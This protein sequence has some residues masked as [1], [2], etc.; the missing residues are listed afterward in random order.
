MEE[1]ANQVAESSVEHEIEERLRKLRK[2]QPF[3]GVHACPGS[4]LDVPDEQAA[5]LVILRPADAYES[6]NK[7]NKEIVTAILDTHGE[8]R[9]VYR[10]MLAF[11]APQQDKMISLNQAA[12][13]FLAWKSIKDDREQL[14]LDKSQERE[15]ESNLKNSDCAIEEQI[16]EAYKW[17]LVPFV[18]KQVDMHAIFWDA[19][20]ISGGKDGIISKAANKMI[21]SGQVISVWA[22]MLLLTELNNVLWK[23]SDHIAIKK[24]WEHLCA[25][26][27]LPRLANESVLLDTIQNGLSSPEYFAFASG[28]EGDRYIGLKFNQ[29]VGIVE[30]SGY[31]VKVSAAK[32]QLAEDEAKRQA[33]EAKK[34]AKSSSE[35]TP[36][37]G[38]GEGRAPVFPASVPVTGEQEGVIQPEPE[39]LKNT[40]FFMS[41]KLDLTRINR[42][43]QKLVEEVIRHLSSAKEAQVEITLDVE[44]KA[45]NG[46][47]REVVR[48]VSENCKTLKVGSF[49]FDD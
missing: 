30:R 33:E 8:R 34:R 21:Q 48:T 25:Y 31:L 35:L 14:N 7:N 13:R 16:K 32:K 49:G 15:A 28:F 5:R 11:I 10:N 20:S 42:D 18:D 36:E 22:P 1:R 45:P 19:M 3:A 37:S 40:H 29:H 26:C 23:E 6:S 2:E 43:V 47:S 24:L 38:G 27:Y 17:L 9:R 41:A 44:V 39:R 12:R 4:S 46:L